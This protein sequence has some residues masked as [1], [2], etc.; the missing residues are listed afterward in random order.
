MPE[1][2]VW[3][4]LAAAVSS[5]VLGGLWYSPA[6]FGPAWQRLSERL[7][8]PYPAHRPQFSLGVGLRH[9]GM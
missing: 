9:D 5:F 1:F 6:L 7:G 8:M 2:N 4:V 3:A